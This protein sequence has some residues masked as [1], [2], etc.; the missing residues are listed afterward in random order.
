MEEG[1]SRL[2]NTLRQS[3]A[4]LERRDA[5]M[6]IMGIFQRLEIF[7]SCQNLLAGLI[8]CFG[9]C[10]RLPG[11]GQRL[12]LR[13]LFVALSQH[14]GTEVQKRE[15]ATPPTWEEPAGYPDMV[16]ALTKAM[17]VLEKDANLE[18]IHGAAAD[19]FAAL[20]QWLGWL[21]AFSGTTD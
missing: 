8:A 17:Q 3:A 16:V 6:E 7:Q 10:P 12:F 15:A 11:L 5:L 1:F 9:L 13:H 18:T 21:G 2:L 14:L 20:F 19:G 4:A